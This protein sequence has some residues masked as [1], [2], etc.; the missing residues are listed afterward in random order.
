[1]DPMIMQ[2][3]INAVAGAVGGNAVAKGAPNTNLGLAGNSIAGL[4]GGIGGGPLVDSLLAMAMTG[5]LNG[6]LGDMGGGL[7]SS[8]VGG[9][10]LTAVV[11]YVKK[12]YMS[13]GQNA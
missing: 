10:I 1:M 3:L 6:L 4:L 5:G 2:T 11:G 13:G 7:A 9:A 12:S 8:A